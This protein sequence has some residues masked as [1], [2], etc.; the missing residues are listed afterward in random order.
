MPW[1]KAGTPGIVTVTEGE[2]PETL[3]PTPAAPPNREPS[4]CGRFP[5]EPS[6][7]DWLVGAVLVV[8]EEVCVEVLADEEGAAELEDEEEEEKENECDEEPVDA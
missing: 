6:F 5:S 4:K 7:C 8:V 1:M 3:P 2:P